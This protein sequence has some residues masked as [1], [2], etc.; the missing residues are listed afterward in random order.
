MT[1]VRNAS[2]SPIKNARAPVRN[3]SEPTN[4]E[5]HLAQS[6]T[7]TNPVRNITGQQLAQSGASRQTNQEHHSAPAWPVK[8]TFGIQPE[9]LILKAYSNSGLL[10]PKSSN[11]NPIWAACRSSHPSPILGC[12]RLNLGTLVQC[13]LN[14]QTLIQL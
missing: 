5:R 3:T 13:K 11:S 1:R 9:Q 4:Q 12:Q 8:N 6:G 10:G 7:L 2:P 14:P